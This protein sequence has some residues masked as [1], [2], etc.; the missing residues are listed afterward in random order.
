VI[1]RRQ[2]QTQQT[3]SGVCPKERVGEFLRLFF[4]LFQNGLDYFSLL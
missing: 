3:A 4:S 1:A 2:V